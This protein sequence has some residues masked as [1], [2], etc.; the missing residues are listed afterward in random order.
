VQYNYALYS[1]ERLWVDSGVTPAPATLNML[2]AYYPLSVRWELKDGRQFIAENIDVRALMREYFKS[3][4]IKL[5]WQ[6]DRRQKVEG[7]Y[8]PSLVHEVREDEVVVKWLIR[9]NHTPIERRAT[10]QPK[11]EYEQYPVVA[12]KGT[13]TSGVDF[14]RQWELRK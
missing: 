1:K 3:H 10:E 5:Q 12:V 6:R 7:D 11:I 2:Q 8:F 9:Y 14:N 4:D 13:P